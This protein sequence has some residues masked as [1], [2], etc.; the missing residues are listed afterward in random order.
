[1]KPTFINIIAQ[2][3][4]MKTVVSEDGDS[5]LDASF[6][7]NNGIKIGITDKEYFDGE[8]AEFF[9]DDETALALGEA[10]IRWVKIGHFPEKE[11]GE[12]RE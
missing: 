2:Y 6:T 10:L 7:P 9:L 11:S 4:Y 5:T 8:Q 12:T 3:E 1:M